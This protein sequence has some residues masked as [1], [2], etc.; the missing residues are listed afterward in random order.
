VYCDLLSK[1]LIPQFCLFLRHQTMDKVQKHNSFNTNTPS[2]ESYRNHCYK[3]S[4]NYWGSDSVCYFCHGRGFEVVLFYA[5]PQGV[6]PL[7]RFIKHLQT[8]GPGRCR[9]VVLKTEDKPIRRVHK[10]C[11]DWLWDTLRR[12]LL[13]FPSPEVKR[14]GREANH[15]ISSNAEVANAWI[16]TYN[17]PICLL[18]VVLS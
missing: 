5:L 12:C 4:Q 7:V 9:L 18:S 3:P 10:L 14:S 13:G 1:F 2:S 17:P 8:R 15:L 6:P 11:S 16:Y